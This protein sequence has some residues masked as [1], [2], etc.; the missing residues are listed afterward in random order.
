MISEGKDEMSGKSVSETDRDW[1]SY[2]NKLFVTCSAIFAVLLVVVY[3][4]VKRYLSDSNLWTEFILEFIQ[5][6][7]PLPVL[8]IFASWFLGFYREKQR[9]QNVREIASVLTGGREE[10]ALVDSIKECLYVDVPWR[11]FIKRSSQIEISV[12][13][14][15]AWIDT[16]SHDLEAFFARGGILK[17]SLPNP[18]NS[19]IT[20]FL[21][22][23]YQNRTSA[24]IKNKIERTAEK[25]EFIFKEHAKGEGRIET[26]YLDRIEWQPMFKFDSRVL[27]VSW[28]QSVKTVGIHSPALIIDLADSGTFRSW[29]EKES[30]A[31]PSSPNSSLACVQG[32]SEPG[33]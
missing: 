16:N 2:L 4:I 19:E 12:H 21:S 31:K 5:N 26:Y 32:T 20:T 11:D 33:D 6:L 30:R 14:L 23:R 27:V 22:R 10:S 18:E 9:E 28:Y 24:D 3:Y 1:I 17:L 8:F 29:Y 25:L 15:H 13:Y 7:F